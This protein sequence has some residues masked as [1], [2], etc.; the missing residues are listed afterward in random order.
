MINSKTNCVGIDLTQ[1][2]PM[3]A[4]AE[5][6]KI[7]ECKTIAD[8]PP[9]V[10]LPILPR[11]PVMV[12]S[13]A[14]THRRGIGISW[15]PECQVP[16]YNHIQN[17]VG[18]IPLVCAWH[19]LKTSSVGSFLGVLGDTR[20]GWRPKG[21]GELLFN[22][23]ELIAKSVISWEKNYSS[24]KTALVIP[25]SLEEAAQQA[26][27]DKCD[28]FLVPRP[29]AIALSWCRDNAVKFQGIG[30]KSEE[31][32]P[33]GHV[34][35]VTMAFD[36]W[37]VV[38][39]EIRAKIFHQESWLIPVRNRVAG[40]S[41]FPRM[42][43][44]FFLGYAG[45]KSANLEDIWRFVF[46]TARTIN[47]LSRNIIVDKEKNKS[48]M[49]ECIMYGWTTRDHKN[50]QGL[51][52][53]EDMIQ[54]SKQSIASNLFPE[55]LRR[56]RDQQLRALPNMVRE[57]CLSVI[58]DG[59][60]AHIPITDTRRIGDF[61]ADAFN[62]KDVTIS[63]GF[64]AVRGAAYT[65]TALEND[66]PCYRETIIPIEIHCHRKDRHGDWKNAYKMLVEGTTIRAGEEYKSK[67][68]VE[69][70]KIR[71]GE[72][73]LKLI[74]RRPSSNGKEI[75][76]EVSAE[77]PEE[78]KRDESVIISANLKPGQGFAK[79]VIDSVK[80]GVFNTL[81]KWRSME[82][83][84]EPPPP[85]LSYLPEVS[86]IKH[87]RD[88]WCDAE[89]YLWK[90]ITALTHNTPDVID[91]LRLLKDKL[92][93]WPRADSINEKRG[94]ILKENPFLHYGVFPS[95]GNI[96][97]VHSPKLA[98]EFID[99]CEKYFSNIHIKR[100]KKETVQWTA[101]WLYLSC[102][103]AIINSS[104][105]NLRH[106]EMET[107]NF[108]LHTIGLCW[109][110]KKDLTAFFEVLEKIFLSER[111]RINN[112]LRACRNIVRF[113]DHALK[114]EVVPRERLDIIV[115]GLVQSL[116][117]EIKKD[118]FQRKFY[119]CVLSF[120]YL[121][122]RRR[123]EDDFLALD[124]EIAQKVDK[125]FNELIMRRQS[126]LSE[127][128]NTVVSITQKFLRKEARFTDLQGIMVEE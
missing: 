104:R 63:D 67:K 106:Y 85:S 39:I 83:C 117:N 70:L 34:V 96:D 75:F 102:P 90:A 36:Q 22:S 87:D 30:D 37:E 93:K 86:I 108:D 107:P 92:N 91:K 73:I 76:R 98:K 122:K 21:K 10:L 123:Y 51:D 94:H 33:I 3:M 124:S 64:E 113:R 14:H 13:V 121:L 71:Q 58:I 29:V 100:E 89:D 128:Y 50:L 15:P 116:E 81:L 12:G 6:C 69:G 24:R 65:A 28:A 4:I 17:G 43:V 41:A 53:W 110:D 112:W 119:N 52:P 120:L 101:S 5:D 57:K 46:G 103:P 9:A 109:N 27:I 25:D 111:E 32:I 42:G 127:K 2:R 35:V 23:E 68:P 72:K 16:I 60:C 66:L 1:H 61:V 126:Q 26:L 7:L 56:I 8:T 40:G 31:G 20:I 59:A 84:E 19:K 105:Q 97:S 79:V 11:E 44:S 115:N 45:S 95:D 88:M 78:T 54:S 62:P 114:P 49:R 80:Q 125:I 118:N 82:P 55:E 47:D 77:I 48:F 74:L 38:P 18:R 99:V